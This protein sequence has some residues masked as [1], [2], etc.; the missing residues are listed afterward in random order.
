MS[1]PI[2]TQSI[3]RLRALFS[4]LRAPAA[5]MCAGFYR[6]E[7]IGPW[8]LRITG[9]PSVALS[10]LPGWQGK[11]FLT[12]TTATNVLLKNGQATQVLLMRCVSSVSQVDGKQGLAL[13]YGADAPVPWRWVRDELRAVDANRMLG[14][15]VINLPLLKRFSFPFLLVREP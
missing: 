14:M 11:R 9:R 7:F 13:H 6:A 5:E 4:T 2:R 10:G 1:G 12:T 8:W 3:T 15:T